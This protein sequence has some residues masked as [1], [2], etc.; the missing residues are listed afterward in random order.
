M[1]WKQGYHI[2]Q[3]NYCKQNIFTSFG[4]SIFLVWKAD[5]STGLVEY[6]LK[7]QEFFQNQ[8]IWIV[9]YFEMSYMFNKNTK[10]SW[11]YQGILMFISIDHLCDICKNLFVKELL[12]VWVCLKIKVFN[13][14]FYKVQCSVLWQKSKGVEVP[15]K[16]QSFNNWSQRI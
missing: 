8:R 2:H 1:N 5:I 3:K 4:N 7:F 11:P 14:K 12:H 15:T 6:S 10:T 16:L 9:V 13:V